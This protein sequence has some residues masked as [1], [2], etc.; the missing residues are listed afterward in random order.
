MCRFLPTLNSAPKCR[1]WCIKYETKNTAELRC[2]IIVFITIPPKKKRKLFFQKKK[3]DLNGFFLLLFNTYVVRTCDN[4]IM[5]YK[6]VIKVVVKV[7]EIVEQRNCLFLLCMYVRISIPCCPLFIQN[8]ND[9]ECCNANLWS[10][11]CE[12]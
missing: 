6:H 12:C 1:F 9:I 7:K 3:L 10:E 4:K 8:V 11:Q 2:F 5:R